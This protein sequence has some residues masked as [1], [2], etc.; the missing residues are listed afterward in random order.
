MIENCAHRDEHM[1]QV[2]LDEGV[3]LG[4]LLENPMDVKFVLILK[5]WLLARCQI[6]SYHSQLS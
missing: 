4:P 5:E 2:F 1:Y 6:V 3:Q